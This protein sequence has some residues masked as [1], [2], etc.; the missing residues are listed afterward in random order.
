MVPHLSNAH[1]HENLSMLKANAMVS[2]V[3]TAI[4]EKRDT[5]QKLRISFQNSFSSM[6]LWDL[7]VLLLQPL[8]RP[9]SQSNK[10]NQFQSATKTAREWP[11]HR[12]VSPY[13]VCW[14]QRPTELLPNTQLDAHVS[15]KYTAKIGITA[16][17]MT[18]P[19]IFSESRFLL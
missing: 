12:A 7:I 16:K 3:T 6:M 15:S 5:I 14:T 2:A 9:I 18:N 10:W 8:V 11:G 4:N 17:V 1:Q 19:V 13:T